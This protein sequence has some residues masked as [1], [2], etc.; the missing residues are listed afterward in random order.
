MIKFI[1]EY[2]SAFILCMIVHIFLN[3]LIQIY[4]DLLVGVIVCFMVT[5]II[6]LIFMFTDY[7]I[8]KLKSKTA[9]ND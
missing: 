6:T 9:K 7:L 8:E 3:S 1:K 4:G 5:L 2:L